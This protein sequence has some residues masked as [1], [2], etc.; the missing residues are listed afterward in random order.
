MLAVR[1]RQA[2]GPEVLEAVDVPIPTAGAGQILV[3]HEAVGL[4]YIDTYQRSGLYPIRFPAV[5]GMEAAGRVEAVGEGVDRFKVGDAVAYAGG[6]G[7]YGE[8]NA[9]P[10]ARAVALPAAVSTRIAAAALLKGMTVEYLLC[11]CFS[12]RAGQSIL[13]HAAAGGV[14]T[15]LIQWAKAIGAHVIGTVGSEEKAAVASSYGCDEVILYRREDVA[16]RVRALTGGEGVPVVYDSV[17]KDTFE[18]SLGA[19]ARRGTLVSFGNASGAVTAINPLVLM[20]R[21][22]LFFTRPTLMDYTASREDLELSAGALFAMIE[23]GKVKIDI[24]QTFPLKDARAAH[25]ALESRATV[26]ASLLIP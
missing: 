1:A 19:L 12:V 3:R 26:G 20:Q 7:A 4:N 8:F 21:G 17:G 11:R 24:G 2:G 9:V 25:E 13:V 22:S 15:I 5:L 18:A 16:E 6:A 14:G 23:S 10:A